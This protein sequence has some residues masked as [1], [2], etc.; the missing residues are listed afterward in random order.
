MIK[1]RAEMRPEVKENL[2]GGHGALHFTHIFE[3]DELTKS[4]M[5]AVISLK[6][7]DSIGVHPHGEEGEAYVV[8]DGSVTV[9]EDG[10][11]YILHAGDA[12]YCT[13]GH[14][15][16]LLNHTDGPAAVLAVILN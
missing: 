12:E 6:P 11:D 1:H 5:F 16:A 4:R 13:G 7:G 2:K 3:P 15:H 10:T 14:T 9:T 8:L